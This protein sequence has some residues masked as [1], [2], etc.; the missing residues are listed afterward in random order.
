MEQT[1]PRGYNR[2]SK[3][4]PW[5]SNTLSYYIVKKNYSRSHFKKKRSDYFYD[6]FAFYRKLVKTL[7]G[8]TGLDG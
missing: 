7:S 5:Y 1:V 8:L 3:F 2:K 4:P 6:K